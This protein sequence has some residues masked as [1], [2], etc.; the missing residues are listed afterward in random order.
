MMTI[1]PV[2][3]MEVDDQ[4]TRDRATH[5]GLTYFFCSTDCKEE[6][7]AHPEEYTDGGRAY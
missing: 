6:F 7:E 5:Q 2:C 1:D 3:G 4:S